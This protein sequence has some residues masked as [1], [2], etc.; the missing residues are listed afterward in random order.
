MARCDSYLFG[1][2]TWYACT[3]SSFIPEGLGNATDWLADA[4]AQ[5]LRIGS[6]P[7]AGAVVVYAAGGGY[8][9]F[10]HVGV[11]RQVY[12]PGSFLV[13]EM[14]FTAWD[15]TDLRISSLA[16]VEGFIYPPDGYVPPG[17]GQQVGGDPGGSGDA[18]NAWVY[19]AGLFNDVFPQLGAALAQAQQT[20]DS[21]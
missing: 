9:E 19:V 7:V 15:Q 17:G 1:E 10:G 20:L 13:S 21:I 12:S 4:R 14:N 16:D 8:S 18:A 6:V 2:C 5:G 11:V 3:Q